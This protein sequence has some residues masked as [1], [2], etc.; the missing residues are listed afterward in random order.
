MQELSI[1]NTAN[2]ND[3]TVPDF[4]TGLVK[5]MTFIYNLIWYNHYKPFTDISAYGKIALN[6]PL[7]TEIA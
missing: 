7:E 3:K 6:F 2:N 1:L 5:E 4:K